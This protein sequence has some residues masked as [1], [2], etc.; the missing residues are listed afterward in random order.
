MF[1][2]A[3]LLRAVLSLLFIVSTIVS[4]PLYVGR[5]CA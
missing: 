5:V 2:S 1:H 4:P 3:S